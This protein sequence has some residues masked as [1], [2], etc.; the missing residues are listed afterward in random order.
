MTK[1][2]TLTQEDINKTSDNEFNF[3]TMRCLP[4]MDA[5][6]QEFFENPISTKN[7]YIRIADS[8]F[9]GE[10]APSGDIVFNPGF[11]SSGKA[12]KAMQKFINAHMRS[13]EPLYTHKIAGIG[14]ML[15]KIVTVTE[16]K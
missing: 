2:Y 13:F 8:I 5:I 3:G 7:I 1:E 11:E 12:V 6:P 9:C 15:S 14:F 4:L 16:S 10:P